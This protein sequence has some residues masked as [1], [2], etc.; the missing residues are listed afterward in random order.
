MLKQWQHEDLVR[1]LYLDESGF[2]KTSPLTYSYVKRGRQHRI[3]KPQRRGRRISILG[4]WQPGHQFDYGLVVGGF[5]SKRYLTLMQLSCP[6]SPS[7]LA[8]D[9]TNYRHYSRW[10]FLSSL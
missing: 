3:P 9:W 6:T 7:T 10:S 1:L 2:E 4:F 5:N 8:G